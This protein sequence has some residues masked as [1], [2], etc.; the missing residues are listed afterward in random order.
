MAVPHDLQ[1]ATT[2]P[3]AAV[4]A[5]GS[6]VLRRVLA[7][8]AGGGGVAGVL[9]LFPDLALGVLAR[10]AARGAGVL[11]GSPVLAHP[12]GWALPGLAVPIV[13]TQVC[14]AADFCVLAATLLGWSLGA[15]GFVRG[16]L[17]A[18]ALC[19]P[20]AVAT[21][22]LRLLVVVQVH[23]WVIPRL[24]PNIEPGLHMLA[25]VLVFLPALIGLHL[26]LSRHAR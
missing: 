19:V 17:C 22:V 4:G 6:L 10:A 26:L 11:G 14:S 24:P 23:R 25:G 7:A 3:A 2:S 1:N 15:R 16:T 13:V 8:A 20:F 9:C 12:E 18:W 5:P 21:N